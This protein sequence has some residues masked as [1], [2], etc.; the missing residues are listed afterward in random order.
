DYYAREAIDF[1][2]TWM[3]D[4][5]RG[6][7]EMKQ[8]PDGTM[9]L[10]DTRRELAAAPRRAVLKGWKAAA[11]LACDRAQTL[12]RLTQLPEV[13]RDGVSE[14]EIRAFLDRCVEHQMMVHDKR[15]WLGVAV[16]VPAREEPEESSTLNL[17]VV[18][19]KGTP[20]RT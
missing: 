3:A 1:T 6:T 4:S 7:L 17:A 14:P 5:A 13:Q 9:S 8:E 2:R 12:D 11:Y 20:K 19:A 18:H 16:H 15:N 10:L